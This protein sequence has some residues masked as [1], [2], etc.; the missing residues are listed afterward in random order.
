MKTKL[1]FIIAAITLAVGCRTRPENASRSTL[2]IH[3][4]T[5]RIT[6][7]TPKEYK[8][9]RM[10]WTTNGL[11]VEGLT[12]AVS[13]DA[14]EAQMQQS[15]MN[16]QSFG[17]T[18]QLLQFMS[19]LANQRFGGNSVP[20]IV[21]NYIQ[22]PPTVVTNYVPATSVIAVPAGPAIVTNHN[23]IAIPLPGNIPN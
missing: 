13:V 6:S 17:Q 14:V 23:T 11:E 15:Q 19:V 9:K 1:T 3:I 2:D 4:G 7:S 22:L 18:L 21:T 12:S 20:Q 10:A 8:I 16:Q 5:N